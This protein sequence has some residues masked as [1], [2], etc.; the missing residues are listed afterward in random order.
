L[1]GQSAAFGP[2]KPLIIKI[3]KNCNA[4][5]TSHSGTAIL[6]ESDRALI[7]CLIKFA[8]IRT[9]DKT[10]KREMEIKIEINRKRKEK[11]EKRKEREREREREREQESESESESE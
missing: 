5:V 2:F 1:F 9:R 7:D 10:M 11:R 3:L 8:G 4:S 6:S